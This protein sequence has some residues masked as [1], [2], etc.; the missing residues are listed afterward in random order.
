[1]IIVLSMVKAWETLFFDKRFIATDNPSNPD[2]VKLAQS[3]GFN[4]LFCDNQG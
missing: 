3:Y 1:M 2:Y 4:T